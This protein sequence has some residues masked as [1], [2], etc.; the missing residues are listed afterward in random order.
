MGVGIEHAVVHQAELAVALGHQHV[1]VRE[2]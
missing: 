1:A 2:A